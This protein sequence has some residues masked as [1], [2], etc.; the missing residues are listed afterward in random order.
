MLRP[1]LN[2]YLRLTERRHMAR[3]TPQGLR[4]SFERKARLL[5]HA[6]RGTQQQW[7]RLQAGQRLVHA[8]DIVPRVHSSDIVILYIHGGG[9]VFGSPRTHAAM[10][11]QLARRLGARAVLPKYRLA[12]EAPYPAAAEDV[13]A[14]WKGLRATGVPAYNI[15]IGGDSAGGALALGLMSE[16]A[17]EGDAMPAGVFCFSPLAD[18][19]YSGKSFAANAQREAI[20]PP[21]R[22]GEM[23]RH[24]LAG[25]AADDPKV[26]PLFADFIGAAPLWLTVGDSEI[27]CDDA[28]GIAQRVRDQGGDVTFVEERDLPHV[29]PLFHNILPEARHTLNT[30]AAWITQRRAS[31][32]EN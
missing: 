1:V 9:F 4:V 13:R 3:S 10:V 29:W 20:L 6:P 17:R 19:T 22:A 16:L 14:A 7:I 15:F 28:R 30:L 23:T 32:G 2:T 31:Q 11:A 12:P 25:H 5:F 27:L 21:E 18:L 26:S 24:Y 8:L